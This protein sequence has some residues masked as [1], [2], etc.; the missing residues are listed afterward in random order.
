MKPAFL[1]VCFMTMLGIP[2][3]VLN[4]EPRFSPRSIRAIERRSSPGQR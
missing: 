3:V 1:F 2:A 4:D